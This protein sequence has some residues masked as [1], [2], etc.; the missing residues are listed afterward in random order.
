VSSEITNDELEQQV[1]ALVA[2]LPPATTE[3]S[4]FW[5]EQFDRGLAWPSFPVGLGGVGVHP[6]QA[7]L[8][9]RALRA[10][11]APT[12]FPRNPVGLG[13]VGPVLVAHGTAEQRARLLRPLFTCEEIW[14][15]LFSEPGSGSDL[16][17]LATLAVRDGDGWVVNG[18]KVWT[19]FAHLAAWGL[20]LA[21]TD[22]AVP[23]HRGMT[24]F[25]VDMRAPGVEVRPL[26]QLTGDDEFNE[27]F[28]GDV[29]IPDSARIGDVGQGWSVA[30]S[31][32]MNERVALAERSGSLGG[33]SIARALDLWKAAPQ[34]HPVMRARLA[35]LYSRSEALRLTKLRAGA[36]RRRG[37][38][39]PED[40]VGK[41]LSGPLS[42]DI[43]EFCI[44][45][46]GA[47]GLL[48]NSYDPKVVSAERAVRNPTRAFLRSR[49][50]TI[51]GGTSEVLKNIIGERVLGLPGDARD[52]RDRP[53]SQVP[54]N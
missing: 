21:R 53:W 40:S 14:C 1:K 36:A 38:P 52:D 19:T 44:D 45:L 13:M 51:E 3:P 41:S 7:G 39:G 5:G 46:L 12:N 10:A 49:A 23:K 20:L 34:Q 37:V 25:I 11:D 6:A 32:L 2:D 24:A 28:F 15:Q 9:A 30:L 16:A 43:A 8:V 26:R 31:T 29:R 18:Q 54:R 42:Q 22:G 35:Q 33:V 4:R 47:D 17:G 48:L 27:V 50:N